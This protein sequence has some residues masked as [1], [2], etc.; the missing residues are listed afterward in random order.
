MQIDVTGNALPAWSMLIVAGN[1][2][3]INVSD[4]TTKEYHQLASREFLQEVIPDL[5]KYGEEMETNVEFRL[6]DPIRF[7]DPP[8]NDKSRSPSRD[9]P[10]MS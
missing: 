1:V 8:E 3:R 5:K 6:G 9:C 2:H 7:L 10:A 4:F